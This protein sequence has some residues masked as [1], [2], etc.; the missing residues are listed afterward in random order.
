MTTKRPF[1][2]TIRALL[3]AIG[4]IIAIVLTLQLLDLFLWLS[5]VSD[6]VF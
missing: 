1:G 3:A 4:A 6:P 5:E 2:V